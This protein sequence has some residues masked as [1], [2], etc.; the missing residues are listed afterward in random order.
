MVKCLYIVNRSCI[1]KCVQVSS[2]VKIQRIQIWRGAWRPCSGSCSTYPSVMTG[3]TENIS[4]STAKMCR[5]TNILSHNSQMKCFRTDVV[6]DI[7][8]R[9]GL[10]LWWR[11]SPF[12]LHR[13]SLRHLFR[14]FPGV[15]VISCSHALV[16]T[17]SSCTPCRVLHSSIRGVFVKV[18]WP[19]KTWSWDCG[20]FTS[21]AYLKWE[22]WFLKCSVYSYV[23]MYTNALS[24]LLTFRALH[25][26]K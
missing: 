14:K 4:H 13:Y 18:L 11:S 7:S 1:H 12:E 15:V 17:L 16:L 2:Q 3:V 19:L 21:L 26:S 23:C 24:W 10:S 5:S 25:S 8:E 20:G 22:K 9:E 6:M